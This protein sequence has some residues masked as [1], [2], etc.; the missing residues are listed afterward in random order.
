MKNC[1]K[2]FVLLVILALLFPAHSLR[3]SGRSQSGTR[4]ESGSQAE[5]NDELPQWARD[6]RRADIITF[7]SFPFTFLLAGIIVDTYRTFQHG[8]SRYAP[9]VGSISRTTGENV[10]VI[11]AAAGGAVLVATADYIIQ[12]VKRERA[13]REAARLTPQEPVIIRTPWPPGGE[14]GDGT[15]EE[16]PLPGIGGGADGEPSG[17]TP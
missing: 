11:S 17:G 6:L 7:G 3:A 14:T 2:G 8:D 12:R 13:A 16:T 1:F 5:K 9:L 10:A 15:P 4:N